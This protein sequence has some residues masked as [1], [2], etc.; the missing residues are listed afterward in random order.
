MFAI[1]FG[2]IFLDFIRNKIIF[3]S[4]PSPF[5]SR[6]ITIGAYAD[7]VFSNPSDIGIWRA[8]VDY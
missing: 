7:G 2:V 4:A 3:V 8:V 6:K 1:A 5:R